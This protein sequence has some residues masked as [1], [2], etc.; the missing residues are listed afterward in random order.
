MFTKVNTKGTHMY[1]VIT[2]SRCSG[3][4]SNTRGRG[5]GFD[6]QQPHAQ[7]FVS[8]KKLATR[9]RVGLTGES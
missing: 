1:F 5:C 2:D 8:K 9:D 3:K 6:L 7:V 4:G